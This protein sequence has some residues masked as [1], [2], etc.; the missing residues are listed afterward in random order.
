MACY[1]M[2]VSFWKISNIDKFLHAYAV[3]KI[4][5]I[6]FKYKID[7]WSK[8][9]LRSKLIKNTSIPFYVFKS[10][11]SLYVYTLYEIII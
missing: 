9:F 7:L 2:L 8:V 1:E 5:C 11:C 4:A 6:N 10:E 3:S